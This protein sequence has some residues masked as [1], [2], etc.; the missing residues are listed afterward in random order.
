MQI[1]FARVS[2]DAQDLQNQRSALVA[3]GCERIF[4]EKISGAKL[5]RPELARM[6][7]TLRAGDVV[8][9]TR[10]DRL[11]RSTR[12]LLAITDELNERKAG[13]RSIAEPW[14]DTTSATGKMIMTFF[15][16]IADWE[17]DLILQRTGDGRR[18]AKTRGVKFGRPPKVSEDA[19]AHY[20]RQIEIGAL[21]V[22]QAAKL[23]QVN[24]STVFRNLAK[25]QTG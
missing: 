23:M 8:T 1:G 22:P 4:E 19:W 10:L 18:L 2:T 21:T 17:R 15:A 20:A 25:R 24:R 9:V 12:N 11:A 7:D 13:L 16:G 6:L 14:A 5:D 3:D